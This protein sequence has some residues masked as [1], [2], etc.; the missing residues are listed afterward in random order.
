[1]FLD[2]SLMVDQQA[3]LVER[4][5]GQLEETAGQTE[6]AQRTMHQAVSSQKRRQRYKWIFAG[7]LLA[8]IAATAIVLSIALPG[9]K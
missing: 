6:A 7:I 2:V 4:L 9:R 5:A 3:P 8:I 1:M